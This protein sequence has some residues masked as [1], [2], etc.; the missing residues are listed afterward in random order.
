LKNYW[1]KSLMRKKAEVILNTK[2]LGSRT[3]HV[4]RQTFPYPSQGVVRTDI[5]DG[6][7]DEEI[8]LCLASQF[9]SKAYRLTGN[10]LGKTFPLRNLFLTF[11]VPTLPS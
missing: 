5:L 7:P 6:M 1:L 2:L 9:V 10:K 11:Q 8:Q 3:V 4:E